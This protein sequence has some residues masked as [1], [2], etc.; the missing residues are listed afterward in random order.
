MDLVST[1]NRKAESTGRPLAGLSA[2]NDRYGPLAALLLCPAGHVSVRTTTDHGYDATVW[3]YRQD[4]VAWGHTDSTD[5]IVETM[6]RWQ[7]GS[8]LDVVQ[9][10]TR[11]D[12][13]D[14]AAAFEVLWRLVLGYDGDDLVRIASAAMGDATLRRLRPWVGHGTLHLLHRDDRIGGTRIGLALYSYGDERWRVHV[15]GHPFSPVL[16]DVDAAVAFASRAAASW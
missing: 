10:L 3:D 5:A 12:E 2:G 6:Q 9:H 15:Y 8:S 7:A 1:L 13:T 11:V 16:D 4:L 14:V